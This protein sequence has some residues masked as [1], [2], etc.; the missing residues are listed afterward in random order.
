[1][2]LAEAEK[3]FFVE[4]ESREETPPYFPF[5]LGSAEKLFVRAPLY[6]RSIRESDMCV[7]CACGISGSH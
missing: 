4:L 3:Y 7:T 1:M 2:P 6:C 5:P